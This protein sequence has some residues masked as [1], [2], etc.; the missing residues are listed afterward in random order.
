MRVRILKELLF[1]ILEDK[2]VLAAETLVKVLSVEG[3]AVNFF[4]FL[5][6]RVE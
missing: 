1:E 6:E 2:G 3:K 4:H 5:F